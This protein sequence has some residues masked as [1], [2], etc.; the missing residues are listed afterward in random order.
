MT[1]TITDYPIFEADQVL[2]QKHLNQLVSYLEEQDRL[3]RVYLHGMG[4]VCGLEILK[5]NKSS[6]KITCGTAITSLGFLIP[7][8]GNYYD[9]YKESILDEDFLEADTSKHDYLSSIYQSAATYSSL[10]SCIELLPS[11]SEDEEKQALT[12]EILVNK[13]VMLLLESPLID[14]KNC[15]TVDCADKGKRLELKVKVL[16][17]DP[18][19]LQE[20]KFNQSNCAYGYLNRLKLPRFNVPKTDLITGSQ[21]NNA[22]DNIIKKST[23]PLSDSIKEVHGYFKD[24]FS[25]L[26]NYD[27]LQNASAIISSVHDKYS[28]TVYLQYVWDWL[29]DL[30]E[31]QNEISDYHACSLSTCCP[32]K[33]YFPFHVL[34][35]SSETNT[36]LVES[37][38]EMYNFRTHF[39]TSGIASAK[40]KNELEILK[41]FIQKLI[42][43]LSN[44]EI[45]ASIVKDPIR[46]TPSNSAIKPLS[47]R[48]IPYYY[49]DTLETNKFW[50]PSLSQKNLNKN[51]L[52]YNSE[53]YNPSNPQV[54]QP[55]LYDIFQNDFYRVEGHVGKQYEEAITEIIAQ[56]E[57]YRLPFKVVALNAVNYLNKEIDISEQSDIWD[58]M[59]L[60]YDLAREKVFNITE[61]VITWIKNNKSKIE[62]KYAPM[63][64]QTIINLESILKESR[65]L[66]VEDLKNFIPRYKDFYEVFEKLNELFLMHRLCI[67]FISGSDMHPIME[68]LIDHFDEIN[69]LFLEDPFTIIYEEVERRWSNSVK[70]LFLSSF[71]RKHP[72]VSHRAGVPKGGTFIVVY[73]DNSIFKKREVT[74]FNTLLLDKIKNY[75][76]LF[77]FD[78]AQLNRIEKSNVVKKRAILKGRVNQKQVDEKW[79][80]E[81]KRLGEDFKLS[82]SKEML[83]LPYASRKLLEERMNLIFDRNFGKVVIPAN[84]EA[85]TDLPEKVIIADFFLPYI[86]CGSGNSINIVINRIAPEIEPI[87]ADFHHRDFN[88]DDFFT[89]K[90][91]T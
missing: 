29:Q 75:K 88:D 50:S 77:D 66:L 62:D 16:L 72:G 26:V 64:D 69:S 47:G 7:F 14:E 30:A 73:M 46:I 4:V 74:G 34:L 24:S 61:Y 25:D 18:G 31:T 70:E 23:G 6:I 91:N 81:K 78:E 86:C 40:E 53:K 27:R 15:I 39:I 11:N 45:N 44:F 85:E 41:G 49:N 10:S 82:I 67:S 8:K 17:V 57:Q 42:V 22:F 58:D 79:L 48:A 12:E 89:N 83:E 90:N 21:V 68:D 84:E 52:S 80:V 19:L 33:D 54:S 37:D 1:Q 38:D 60:D 5:P 2:S 32:D 13:V 35:G 76:G 56:K 3:S 20:L 87:V 9:Q 43:L 65:E 36:D 71:L 51:I 55:L 28:D 63:N 59:E